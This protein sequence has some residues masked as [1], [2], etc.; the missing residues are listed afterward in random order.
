MKRIDHIG[1]AVSD[2]R[3]AEKIFSDVL[4]SGPTKTERVLDESVIVSFF[5]S[6]ES[7]IELLQSTDEAGPIARHI[8]KRGQGLHHIAFHVDDLETELNRLQKL[9]YRVVS[10]PKPGADNKMIAFLHPADVNK[11]LVEL[12]ANRF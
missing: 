8:E 2:M 6:G 1:I 9:G 10:G 3:E 11:V 5:Q 4:G 12:C 7:K